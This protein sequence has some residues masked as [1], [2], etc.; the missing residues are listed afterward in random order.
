MV[1][2]RH[3]SHWPT[4]TI[5]IIAMAPAI[6]QSFK[7]VTTRHLKRTN[8]RDF[9]LVNEMSDMRVIET[10]LRYVLQPHNDSM[11]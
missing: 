4:Y 5:A 6:A 8:R 3:F 9:G 2:Y 10:I 11:R 1:I 7:T